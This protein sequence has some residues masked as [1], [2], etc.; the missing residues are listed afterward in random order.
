MKANR[1]QLLFVVLIAAAL[2]VYL[3]SQTQPAPIGGERDSHGCLTTAGYSFDD[4]VGACLRSFEMTPD[5]KQ[6]AKLAVEHAGRGYA[7]TVVSFNSFEEPGAY[8]IFFERGEERV[9][10][11]VYI[12]G[13]EV[14]QQNTVELFYYNPANDRDQS[15]NVLCSRQGL[16]SV[17][18]EVPPSNTIEDTI[19]LLLQGE[20]TAQE[21]AQGV[22][23]EYPLPGLTLLSAQLGSDGVLTL[24]FDDA[25]NKTVGGA[26]RTGVLWFQIEATAL[27]L[28]G[29]KSVT[30]MPE[31]L[32]QP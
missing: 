28:P 13:G 19:R 15:G 14:A 23:T 9:R 32:F 5:I 16:V 7:L 18:R 17:I 12:R 27:G 26:C 29:V 20:L 21:R 31:E 25:Q 3:L 4:E 1:L 2:G 11:A 24:T 8:D 30:F 6:A 22:S 10:E